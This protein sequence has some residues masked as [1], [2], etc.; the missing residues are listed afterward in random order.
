MDT[1]SL[2][3]AVAI[4]IGLPGLAGACHLGLLAIASFKEAPPEK[5]KQA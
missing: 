2:L 3:V 4:L 5:A 1:A